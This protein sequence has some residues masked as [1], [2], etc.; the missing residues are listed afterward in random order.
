M[1]DSEDD[2]QSC[3]S[4]YATPPLS[5][6]KTVSTEGWLSPKTPTSPHKAWSRN[7]SRQ[8]ESDGSLESPPESPTKP[9]FTGRLAALQLTDTDKFSPDAISLPSYLGSPIKKPSMRIVNPRISD[10]ASLSPPNARCSFADDAPRQVCDSQQ[11]TPSVSRRSSLN[12]RASD[13]HTSNRS[14]YLSA[15]EELTSSI[16]TRPDSPDSGMLNIPT[17]S[18]SQLGR[19]PIRSASSPLRPNRWVARGG[20][21]TASRRPS[22]APDRFIPPRRPPNVTKQSF[23]LNK[24]EKR[25]I[26]EEKSLPGGNSIPDPFSRRLRRSVR[27]NDE[28]RSLRETHAMLTGRSNLHRRRANPGLRRGTTP[29]AVRQI[30]AGAVWNVGGASAA[31]DTVLGVSNGNGGILGSGTNAPLY[32]SMFLSRSDPD[33]EQEAYERRVALALEIDQMN[34][35]L[36]HSISSSNH[37][38][39]SSIDTP[40]CAARTV[41][42]WKDNSWTTDSNLP[43]WLKITFCYSWNVLMWLCSSE[44]Y[45]QCCE[46]TCAS[47]AF[48]M[49][50]DPM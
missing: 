18:P 15:E 26:A 50:S 37:S 46:E 40:P 21:L 41:H 28:L 23:D 4:G 31:S 17:C 49:S 48:Q 36:D 27:M 47:L 30:S 24:P 11:H 16:T 10:V 8:H 13:D 1:N 14:L 20:S 12:F 32:T 34:R 6:T 44:T 39:A 9:K 35:V 5:P 3:D 25:L 38:T 7:C 19:L 45:A 22:H 33:A 42:V 2:S 29:M 43:R